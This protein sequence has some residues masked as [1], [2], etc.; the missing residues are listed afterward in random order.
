MFKLAPLPPHHAAA[1]AQ[2]VY[3]CPAIAKGCD[4]IAALLTPIDTLSLQLAELPASA[5]LTRPVLGQYLCLI[6]T[7]AARWQMHTRPALAKAL[8]ELALAGHTLTL[9]RASLH[10]AQQAGGRLADAIPRHLAAADALLG[11]LATDL[12]GFL[13]RL[14]RAAGELEADRALLTEQVQADTLHA[15]LLSQQGPAR[16]AGLAGP[17]LRLAEPAEQATAQAEADYLH[18][19]LPSLARYP[20][21]LGEAGQAIAVLQNGVERV[22]PALAGL[23]R[24][25]LAGQA[26]SRL[27]AALPHWQAASATLLRIPG[28][29]RT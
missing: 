26:R 19:L 3:W 7:A 5:A 10:T 15:F 4:A 11:P 21:L 12:A 2:H 9:W 16:L 1:A 14:A 6:R 8:A 22:A 13:A 28:A 18:A 17:D 20:A 27:D 29:P 24:S 23:G 25:R